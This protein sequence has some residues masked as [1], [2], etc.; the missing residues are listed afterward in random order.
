MSAFQSQPDGG[1]PY[2]TGG[3]DGRFGPKTE[4]V[5]KVL[6]QSYGITVDGVVGHQTWQI[7][8]SLENEGPIDAT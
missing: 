2:A 5:V 1:F 6:Q 8:D 3:V 7:V 4:A